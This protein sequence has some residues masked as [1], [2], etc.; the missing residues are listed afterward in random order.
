MAKTPQIGNKSTENLF[1]DFHPMSEWL[2]EPENN[3]LLVHLPDFTKEQIR[4][5]CVRSS[6]I[7]RVTGERQLGDNKW[8]RCNQAFP[9]PSNCKIDKIHAKWNNAILTVTMPKETI[10][11]PQPRKEEPKTTQKSPKAA[12]HKEPKS[13]K[14]FQQVSASQKAADEEPKSSKDFQQ[15]AASPKAADK[16][17]KTSKDFQ[18][19]TEMQNEVKSNIHGE[20]KE[21]GKSPDALTAQKS[22]ETTFPKDA[23][24]MNQTDKTNEV[25]KAKKIDQMTQKGFTMPENVTEKEEKKSITAA[26]MKDV[27]GI[28]TDQN[29]DKQLLINIG[30][31]ALVIVAL[32]AYVSYS[33]GSK[34][35]G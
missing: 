15:A 32:G 2:D 22:D 20:K 4:I 9:I 17:P 26:V 27:K 31:A 13:S 1:E 3:I 16:E 7:V 21:D 35:K 30:V 14:D 24:S 8:S 25:A 23:V 29:E 10:T 18:Q 12:E 11:Q 28:A 34:S 6:R 33:I 5:T 19:I